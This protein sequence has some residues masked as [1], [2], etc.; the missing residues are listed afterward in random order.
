MVGTLISAV[1]SR[2]RL[3]GDR[4]YARPV[5]RLGLSICVAALLLAGCGSNGSNPTSV[6]A[7]RQAQAKVTFPILWL[8]TN[9]AGNQPHDLLVGPDAA[10]A[11]ID[12]AYGKCRPIDT[13]DQGTVCS[14][15]IE[16]QEE[17]ACKGFAVAGRPRLFHGPGKAITYREGG[18]IVVLSGGTYV[19]IFG[20]RPAVAARSLHPLGVEGTAPPQPAPRPGVVG[21]RGC[22]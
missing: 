3:L 19:K 9:Y 15:P 13:G 21:G 8:G 22:K 10:P 18:G 17:D 16:L 11:Q 5:R 12:L 4:G 6:D 20:E 1:D 14:P 7:M 2:G